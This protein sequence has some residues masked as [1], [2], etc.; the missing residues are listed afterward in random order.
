MNADGTGQTFLQSDGSVDE[1]LPLS[2]LGTRVDRE[3]AFAHDHQVSGNFRRD[4][5]VM[6]ADGG[7]LRP[8]GLGNGSDSTPTWAPDSGRVALSEGAHIEIRDV[9]TGEDPV[10]VPSQEP[11]YED[12]NPDWSPDGHTI[13][14]DRWT[15]GCN[16]HG[17]PSCVFH[18]SLWTVDPDVFQAQPVALTTVPDVLDEDP[19]IS[20]DGHDAS[21]SHSDR[22]DPGNRLDLYTVP[23][24]GG[25]PTQLTDTPDF[26]RD[27]ASLVARRRQDRLPGPGA[28][29]RELGGLHDQRER[30]RTCAADDR[31]VRRRP[32]ELA[33]GRAR[34]GL[35][36]PE[37][38]H[39]GARV[40]GARVQPVRRRRTAHTDRRWHSAHATRP[41]R[42][43][44][45]SRPGRRTQTDSRRT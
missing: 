40:A 44:A 23:I 39:A 12:R 4:L 36:A 21:C 26:R 25:T 41:S 31:P 33:A 20:P 5:F 19:S 11:G 27:P 8:L 32:A 2:C 38:R 3:I 18:A 45:S 6:E 7:N 16:P 30:D 13:V 17:I 22:A 42:R 1:L 35:P 24:A 29:S 14:F 15:F 43:P 37:R 10:V 9:K 28:R 34:R